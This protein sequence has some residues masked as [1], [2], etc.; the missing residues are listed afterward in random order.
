MRRRLN[1]GSLLL[2]LASLLSV[3]I[4]QE[5][6][7]AAPVDASLFKKDFDN[8]GR[9]LFYTSLDPTTATKA[10][11]ALIVKSQHRNV[12]N[13]EGVYQALIELDQTKGNPGT[14]DT[15]YSNQS[16]VARGYGKTDTWTRERLWPM[17]RGAVGGY[18]STDIHNNRPEETRITSIKR[19][20]LFGK[21]GTVEFADVCVR[22]AFT[23]GPSSTEQDGKIWLP[24]ADKRGDIARALFYMQLRYGDE[25]LDLRLT[26]C[27]PFNGK[28]AYLSQLLEW[29]ADDPVDDNEFNRNTN[30]CR[31]WQGNRNPFVDYPDLVAKFYGQPQ[32]I[33]PNTRTYQSC[34]N[35]PTQAPT[36]EQNECSLLQPGDIFLLRIEIPGGLELYMTDNPWTGISFAS[37]EGV[38]KLTVPSGGYKAGETFGFGPDLGKDQKWVREEGEFNIGTMGDSIFLYCHLG[39]S[40][41]RPLVGYTNSNEW[42]KPGLDL[43]D[44]GS[45]LSALPDELKDVGSIALPHLDNYKYE[46]PDVAEKKDLQKYMMD[47]TNWRG[48]DDGL[49]DQGGSQMAATH[50]S[51]MLVSLFVAV[52]GYTLL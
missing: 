22:P 14:V 4:G 15:I 44:Y 48:N 16:M 50:W 41:I 43:E 18:A 24:P 28:M 33:E 12:L 23:L 49:G 21:C 45:T 6:E 47:P 36:A 35:V 9:A 8:C 1:A 29:H 7:T 25:E 42:A 40:S 13:E 37:V 32:A 52:A 5:E 2:G 11:F 27:P 17:T 20:M 19:E 34:L 30:A 38:I 46:G 3:G 10:D 26:D 31:Y 51:A 39:D